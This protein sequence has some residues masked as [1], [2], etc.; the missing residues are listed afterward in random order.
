MIPVLHLPAL[1]EGVQGVRAHGGLVPLPQR[2][3]AQP[4]DL[5][6]CS[7]VPYRFVLELLAA[8]DVR[9]YP[10]AELEQEHRGGYPTAIGE[11]LDSHWRVEGCT[12]LVWKPGRAAL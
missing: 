8:Y 9:R 12:V 4:P 7:K 3:A 2:D 6:E 11:G 5:V 10:R 1:D